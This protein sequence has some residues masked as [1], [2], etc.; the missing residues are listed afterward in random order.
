MWW[1]GGRSMAGNTPSRRSVI[2][3]AALAPF[4][5]VAKAADFVGPLT[6]R[7]RQQRVFECRRDA[8]QAELD[9]DP[10]KAMANGDEDRYL[11]RRASFSKTMPHNELGEVDPDAYR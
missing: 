11:D 5:A 4:A 2:A 9:S 6:P 3:A 7:Q 10:P 8:A 1:N